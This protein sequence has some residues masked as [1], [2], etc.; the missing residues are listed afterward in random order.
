MTAARAFAYE[1]STVLDFGAIARYVT[2]WVIGSV[3]S[4]RPINS[5]A[6]SADTAT[7][8]P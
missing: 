4:G 6:C 8:S 7:T 1:V 2:A 5:K 3:P